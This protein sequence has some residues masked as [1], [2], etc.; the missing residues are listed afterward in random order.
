MDALNS[1]ASAHLALRLRH[2][3]RAL[4][5]AVERQAHLAQRLLRPDVTSLCVTD[6]QVSTLLDDVDALLAARE[7]SF[8]PAALTSEEAAAESNLRAKSTAQQARLPL[9]ALCESLGLL[10]FEQE[11]LLLCAAPEIDR[12]YERIYA[13][14]LDDLGRRFPCVE[15]LCSL[16]SASLPER[17]RRRRMLGR[18]GKLRR[19]GLLTACGE[20]PTELRQELRLASGLL[21]FLTGGAPGLLDQFRDPAEMG[22]LNQT[23]LPPGVEKDRVKN[24]GDALRDGR[25]GVIGI[26]GPRHSGHEEVAIALAEECGKPLRRFMPAD[27][28]AGEPAHLLD[29]AL[30]AAAVLGAVLWIHTDALA[31]PD[32]ERTRVACAEKLSASCVPVVLSGSRPWRPATLLAARPYSEIE[33]E[34][35][36]YAARRSMWLNAL[37]D[38]EPAQLEDLAARF[39]VGPSDVRAIARTART[40]ARIAGKVCAAEWSDH[41]G[42]ACAAVTRQASTHFATIVKSKRG[43]ADLVLP[44]P[45]HREVLEVAKFY[46]AW[47]RVAEGWGFARLETGAGGIKALFTGDSGTGKTLAAEV[48]AGEL[49]MPLLKVDLAQVVSKWVGETEKHLEQAFREAEDGHAV[50]FFDE[51]DALFGKRGEVQHGI[52]RYAN[53]EVSFLLQRLEDYCGLVILASNLKDN[54]D[55]AFTRRFHVV[56]HFPRPE[57]T[58]R[59][60]IW[61]L[62]FARNAP[63]EDQVDLAALST[64]NM[65][66]AGIVG[67]AR[68]AA[69]LAAAEG[70]QSIS[71]SHLVRAI[72]RQYR[73][74]ARILMPSELGPYAGLLQETK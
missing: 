28:P 25:V 40:G 70:M 34:P 44:A 20:P 35:P 47:P 57:P 14:I 11:A 23:E 60:R 19:C 21:D 36:D 38:A 37:P 29:E 53:L 48:I 24:L 69:L 67:S 61:Q 43:P 27:A 49:G 64:L 30:R 5:A 41:V 45:L 51:A 26:W 12:S 65:T 15:L 32:A 3:N 63:L 74:E 4:R 73:R 33:L 58:E 56:V 18:F 6:D 9:D 17:L 71:K 68:T 13:Y 10:H 72:A 52:D 16:T 1:L 39:R 46:R 50:L 54:I 2:L 66:G 59:H 7:P 42:A 8:D 62:A 55:S 31:E 22:V